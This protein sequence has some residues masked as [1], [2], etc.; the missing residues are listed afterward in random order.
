MHLQRLQL[1]EFRLYRH[2]DLSLTSGGL[3]ISGDNASGKST[4]VEAVALLAVMRSPR[5]GSDRELINIASGRD[6][7]VAP[8]ARARADIQLAGDNAHVEVGLQVDDDLGSPLRKLVRV[9]GRPVRAIDAV[10]TLKIVL[11]APEDVA[12][13][14]GPPS[15]RRRYLDLLLSQLD[16]DYVRSLAKYNRIIEQRNSLLRQLAK[17]GA[18]EHDPET[19]TQLTFWDEE[20]VLLGARL[21]AARMS[22]LRRLGELAA[23]RFEA[24]ANGLRLTV[25]YLPSVGEELLGIDRPIEE[26]EARLA[27]LLGERLRATRRDELRRGVTLSGPH[28]DDFSLKLDEMEV[29]IYGSRGQ[30]RLTLVALKLAEADVIAERSGESPVVLLDDVLSELDSRNRDL[31]LGA[32][33]EGGDQIIVT[34]ADPELFS[35]PQLAELPRITVKA[36]AVVN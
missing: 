12:L 32:L 10:G 31:L 26:I 20:L 23:A 24:L 9:N 25:A 36:G 6:L 21:A 19:L 8:Y 22:G 4:L 33:A 17:R 16:R 2:L 27:L 29:G 3:A 1:D 28:R 5:T 13:V 7:G 30:Q 18:A 15:Q 35:G 14:S 34:A 11:F